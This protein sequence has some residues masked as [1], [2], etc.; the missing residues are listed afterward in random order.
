MNT[1]NGVPSKMGVD[2][3]FLSGNRAVMAIEK[4]IG[5]ILLAV[6]LVLVLYGVTHEGLNPLFEQV[7]GKF[8]EVQIMLNLKDDVAFQGCY[9][10]KVSNLGGGDDFLRQIGA[11]GRDVIFNVCRDATCNI[12]IDSVGDY[13][14]FDGKFYKLYAGKWIEYNSVFLWD[15]NF[16]KFRKELY[17]FGVAA[18]GK[19]MSS[20]F[21]NWTLE[22]KQMVSDYFLPI[23]NSL[24]AKS[25][26]KAESCDGCGKG[27]QICKKEECD[28]IGKNLLIG[29]EYNS[30]FFWGSCRESGDV[31]A[32]EDLDI[33]LKVQREELIKRFD[34]IV[35]DKKVEGLG[36][37]YIIGIEIVG[38]TPII[39]L[40]SGDKK[41]GL[42][43]NN[44][45]KSDSDIKFYGRG[46]GGI[47]NLESYP[48]SLV[49]WIGS[50]WVDMGHED[51]Y[52][53]PD[54]YFNEA[55]SATLI[56]EFIES[57]CR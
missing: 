34:E 42:K 45:L 35:A 32:V 18:A 23:Q 46:K 56:K 50:E 6:F 11:E 27:P 51:Y 8:D 5:I 54:R 36:I 4:L 43:Y 57:K 2:I 17:N 13:M 33:R 44:E 1:R 15:V 31:K 48:F 12:S 28:A 55:Y 21:N 29:C 52:R 20:I 10:E 53:L 30:Y 37:E 41:Y 47:V 19:D 25:F 16:V 14:T 9:S 3:P 39:T 40:I 7:G 26:S 22:R 49:M 38:N 24:A